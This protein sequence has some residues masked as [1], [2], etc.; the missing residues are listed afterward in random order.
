ML[1]TRQLINERLNFSFS[2]KISVQRQTEAAECGLACLAM[3]VSYFGYVTDVAT[4]R[5]KFSL[6]LKGATLAQLVEIAHGLKLIPRPVRLDIHELSELRLPCILHWNM[7]HFVVLTKV[8]RSSFTIHDP[9]RGSRRISLDEM[10]K[11]FTGVALEVIPAPDFEKKIQRQSISLWQMMGKI[12]GL[13]QSLIQIGLLALALEAFTLAAPFFTQLVVDQAIVTADI[14]LLITLALGFGLL[15]LIAASTEAVRGY[16]I[17]M[18]STNLNVQWAANVFRHLLSLPIDFFQKRHMGDV[19]SR[20]NSIHTIQSSLT[21]NF[22][23]TILDGFLVSGITVVMLIY[24][25]QLSY[26]CFVTIILYILLRLAFYA[27][28]MSA[29][30]NAVAQEAAQQS[31]FMESIR[32]IQPIRLFSREKDRLVKWLNKLVDQKNASLRTQRISLLAQTGNSVLVGLEEIAVVAYGANLVIGGTFSVGMLLAF[33]SYKT[34]FSKRC[35]NLVDKIFELKMLR[36][37]NERLSDIVLTDAEASSPHARLIDPNRTPTI[38]AENLT[39]AYSISEKPVFSNLSF[40]I[41]AG[42][43]VAIVGPSGCGKSTLLKLL[44]GIYSPLNGSVKVDGVPLNELNLSRYRALVGTVMQEDTLFAGTIAEN[45]CFFA[46]NMDSDWIETCAK[47]AS[48]HGE[49]MAMPM[50]YNSLVGDMGSALSGGQK[51][52]LLLARALYGRP[53]VLMLDEA[54]SHL[55]ITNEK[56]VNEVVKKMS[57]TKIIVAH[58]KETIEQADRTISLAPTAPRILQA[59]I[60]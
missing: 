20:F 55:D 35:A 27:A 39:F 12:Y 9:A 1:E 11:H 26:I 15:K 30:E 34:Q 45:I 42:E 43:C 29:T 49:I 23:A 14:D 48:I 19:V 58:R 21:V 32:G 36:F 47:M 18:M 52:R 3:V 24:S 37:Q 16:A 31:L 7:D 40:E 46:S 25:P 56:I 50:G 28:L 53:K 5:K 13:K 17:L 44:L 59:A 22:V 38:S 10:S 6:S 4:L 8:K 41:G 54:T 2:K 57:L 60:N 51:Q 33:I